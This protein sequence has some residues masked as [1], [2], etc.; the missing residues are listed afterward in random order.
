MPKVREPSANGQTHNYARVFEE[1]GV[2]LQA[3]GDQVNLRAEECPFCTEDKFY[4]NVETGLYDCKNCQEKGNVTTFLTW[5][6]AQLLSK[7][8]AEDRSRLAHKRGIA[9]QTV[10]RFELAFDKLLDRW[11]LPFKSTKGSVVNI[12]FYY[13]K[14][15]KDNKC[16]LKGL[17]NLHIQLAHTRP[18]HRQEGLSL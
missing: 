5:I 7:T 10:E 18:Q 8:T 4:V 14:R 6:H 17:L 16:N 3:N 13:W 12:Q 2:V 9:P 1:F 15:E 11:L